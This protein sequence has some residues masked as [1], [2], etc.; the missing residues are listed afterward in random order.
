MTTQYR[1]APE[2]AKLARPLIRDHH[3]HLVD[4]RIEYVMRDEAATSKG[5]TVWGKA[6]KVGG[7]NAFIAREN[8]A[9]DEDLAEPDPFFVIEIAED[10]WVT[11]NGRQKV[12]L[13]DH[14]LSHLGARIDKK[15][16]L[17]LEVTGHAA[18]GN[19]LGRGLKRRTAVDA[20]VV[21]TVQRP[22]MISAEG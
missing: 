13:V 6:R 22:G 18:A 17:V 8:H 4:V 19:D 9:L 1:P 11:L 3:R 7:L 10:I 15:G 21:V 2:V 5:Q 16:E 20:R 14:E 12:A